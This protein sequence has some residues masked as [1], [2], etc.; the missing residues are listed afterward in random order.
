MIPLPWREGRGE[1]EKIAQIVVVHGAIQS[2]GESTPPLSGVVDKRS[3]TK[4]NCK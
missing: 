2:L 3:P 4:Y 1:G